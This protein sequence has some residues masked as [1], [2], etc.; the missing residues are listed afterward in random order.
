MNKVILMGMIFI[1]LF[2]SCKSEQ[3]EKKSAEET[4]IEKIDTLKTQEEPKGYESQHKEDWEKHKKDSVRTDNA[5][6]G[7]EIIRFNK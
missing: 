2:L 7:H 4:K 3:K 6:E 5:A 1:F